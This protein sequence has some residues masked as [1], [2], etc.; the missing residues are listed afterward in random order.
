MQGVGGK[1]INLPHRVWA[2]PVATQLPS[3][4]FLTQFLKGRVLAHA[5]VSAGLDPLLYGSGLSQASFM[6]GLDVVSH[7]SGCDP[8]SFV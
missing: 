7:G 8:V 5:S 3:G 4:L 2:R 1:I 6:V